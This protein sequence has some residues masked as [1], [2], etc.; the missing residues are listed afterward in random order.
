MFAKMA[1]EQKILIKPGVAGVKNT[2][3][4]PGVA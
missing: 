3:C 1:K 2:L 4:Q